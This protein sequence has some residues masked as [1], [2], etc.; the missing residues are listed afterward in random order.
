MEVREWEN[1]QPG[2]L[3][4][5]YVMVKHG[6]RGVGRAWS[7]VERVIRSAEVTLS[8]PEG[9]Y[10]HFETGMVGRKFHVT[11]SFCVN[12]QTEKEPGLVCEVKKCSKYTD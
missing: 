8:V 7:D 4:I 10:W 12:P 5:S 9:G 2:D 11:H 3:K 6:S 1:L